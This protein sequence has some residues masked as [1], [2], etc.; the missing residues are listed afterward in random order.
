MRGTRAARW[1]R[2]DDDK[3]SAV[4]QV[5]VDDRFLAVLSKHQ[6]PQAKQYLNPTLQLERRRDRWSIER[7]CDRHCSLPRVALIG[8]PVPVFALPSLRQC[9]VGTAC[10]E[11][12][13]DNFGSIPVGKSWI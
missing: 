12:A 7:L 6:I 3:T 13:D 4:G 2:L 1:Y 5:Y 8:N 10:P 11:A 9:A